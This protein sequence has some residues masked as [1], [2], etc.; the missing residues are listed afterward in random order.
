MDDFGIGAAALG[1]FRAVLLAMRGTGRTT[2]L[3]ERYQPGDRVIFTTTR[4]AE[5]V[6]R[7]AKEKHGKNMDWSVCD[8]KAP[9]SVFSLPRGTPKGRMHFDHS[10]LEDFYE[11]KLATAGNELR[12][13]QDQSSGFGEPHRETQEAARMRSTFRI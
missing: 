7:I 10:W 6:A 13:I 1:A 8:P 2:R 11:H 3:I 4:E 5:R 12:H 9:G